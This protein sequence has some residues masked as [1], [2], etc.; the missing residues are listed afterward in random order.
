MEKYDT[1]EPHIEVSVTNDLAPHTANGEW[2]LREQQERD[3]V[4]LSELENLTVAERKS[5]DWEKGKASKFGKRCHSG[6]N[7]YR[8]DVP[9]CCK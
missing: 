8:E 3:G 4:D 2:R 5:M 7:C 6:T 1:S 9:T